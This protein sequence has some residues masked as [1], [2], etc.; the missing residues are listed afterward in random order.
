MKAHQA[1]FPIAAMCRV[2][3]V[4]AELTA[5][6][7]ALIAATQQV[8]RHRTGE[9]GRQV[10]AERRSR[11]IV[12]VGLAPA[13]LARGL[14]VTRLGRAV[15]LL[16]LVRLAL[17][18]RPA[19]LGPVAAVAVTRVARTGLAFG[20][21]GLRLGSGWCSLLNRRDNGQRRIERLG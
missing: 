14:L 4:E 1:S 7:L 3:G 8:L 11:A 20:P 5:A 21:R 17:A 13:A 18:R 9:E 12:S 10:L 16:A 6:R 19:A 2:L 15:T